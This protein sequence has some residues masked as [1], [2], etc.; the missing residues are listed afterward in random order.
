M[1]KRKA[2]AEELEARAKPNGYK[3]ATHR[4]RDNTQDDGKH[5]KKTKRNQKLR[6]GYVDTRQ[7]AKV[8]VRDCY[9][10]I[11]PNASGMA[12]DFFDRIVDTI[13]YLPAEA[14]WLI[15]TV[16]VARRLCPRNPSSTPMV[17]AEKVRIEL[18]V[19]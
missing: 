18:V 5:N 3:R 6:R 8:A 11:R 2:T 1:A 19:T 10:R 16:I 7:T 12:G 14:Y 17:S 9:G 13:Q 4:E 15:W